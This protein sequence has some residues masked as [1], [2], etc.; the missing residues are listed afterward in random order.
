MERAH[1][2]GGGQIPGEIM[3]PVLCRVL[4]VNPVELAQLTPEQIAVHS[5]VAEGIAV[6]RWLRQE[7][8]GNDG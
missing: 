4:G 6:A 8:Q 3:E 7:Q 2:Q 5:G 1:P